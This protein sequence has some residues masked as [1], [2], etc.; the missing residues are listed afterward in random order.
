MVAGSRL[1]AANARRAPSTTPLQPIRSATLS[2]EAVA[3]QA[4]NSSQ[5]R[6]G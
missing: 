5:D 6:C 4:V 2:I 3:E 1:L